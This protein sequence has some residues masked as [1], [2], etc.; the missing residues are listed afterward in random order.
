MH[1]VQEQFL[2]LF[3]K[4]C[5]RLA[6]GLSKIQDPA[7]S[8]QN[9]NAHFYSKT[10]YDLKIQYCI[11]F[12]LVSIF[13]LLCQS[14]QETN[15]K[16]ASGFKAQIYNSMQMTKVRSLLSSF[17]CKRP[18]PCPTCPVRTLGPWSIHTIHTI[19]CMYCSNFSSI[20]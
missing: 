14:T 13:V 1:F 7:P 17:P 10:L 18:L 15:Q 19:R 3:S 5:Y 20:K 9:S 2:Q 11:H 8:L 16:L 6:P 4:Y 12:F